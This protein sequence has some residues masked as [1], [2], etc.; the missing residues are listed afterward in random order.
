MNVY[1]HLVTG[2]AY[3]ELVVLIGFLVFLCFRTRSKGLIWV[4]AALALQAK[5]LSWVVAAVCNA[6]MGQWEPNIDVRGVKL[7][8]RLDIVIITSGIE[9][10]LCYSLGLLGVFLIYKEW[11]QGKFN[12]PLT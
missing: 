1:A 12:Y 11:R 4:A 8:R 2:I 7:L 5:V 3:V 6:Y 9:V 10:V